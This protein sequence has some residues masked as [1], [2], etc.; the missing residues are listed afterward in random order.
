ML[1]GERER[2]HVGNP[3][4]LNKTYVFRVISYIWTCPKTYYIK[5]YCVFIRFHKV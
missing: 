2:E 5:F 3:L 4:G 1:C